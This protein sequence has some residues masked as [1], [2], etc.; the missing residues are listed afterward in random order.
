M[1]VSSTLMLDKKRV[2]QDRRVC[3][4]T[5]SVISSL[6]M[7]RWEGKSKE[8]EKLNS[9]TFWARILAARTRF[10]AECSSDGPTAVNCIY[11]S[12]D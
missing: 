9:D 2:V 8:S 4:H 3:Y 5:R 7:I 12:I 10:A 11:L 6:C 1:T